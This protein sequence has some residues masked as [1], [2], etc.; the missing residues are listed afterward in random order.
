LLDAE[1]DVEMSIITYSLGIKTVTNV[2][3]EVT[4]KENINKKKDNVILFVL[5]LPYM[6]TTS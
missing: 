2:T 1:E 5:L 6:I 4:E 3:V